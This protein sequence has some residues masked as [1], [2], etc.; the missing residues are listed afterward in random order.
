MRKNLII[1][2]LLSIGILTGCSGGNSE[3]QREDSVQTADSITADKETVESVNEVEQAR[4]DSMRRD[5]IAKA[6]NKANGLSILD[7]C[8]WN[9]ND[10]V[11]EAKAYK[12]VFPKLEKKGFKCIKTI[13]KKVDYCDWG[14]EDEKWYTY[15][16]DNN[17]S[18]T[19]IKFEGLT[20]LI[21]F[22]NK[23]Q[24]DEFLSTVTSNRFKKRSN[25][26]YEGPNPDCYWN[27]TDIEV[28]GNTVSLNYRFEC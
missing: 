23:E 11:M 19:T 2:L 7:F 6:E 5:S 10:K 12:K 18:V 1:S 22:P 17:G 13:T 20:T 8:Q 9:S 16:K 27:G 26:N 21:Q 28:K 25:G 24:L 15:S 4:L 3:K 14:E